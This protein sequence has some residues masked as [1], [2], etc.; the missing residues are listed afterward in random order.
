MRRFNWRDEWPSSVKGPHFHGPA[1]RCELPPDLGTQVALK[2]CVD[3]MAW[4]AYRPATADTVLVMGCAMRRRL[5]WTTCLLLAVCGCSRKEPPQF[6]YIPKL[7]ELSNEL[8]ADVKRELVKYTGTFAQPRLIAA[9]DAPPADL[10]RGQAVYQ[11]RCVQCHGVSGDG[12]GPAAKF[13]YPRPRDYRRGLFKFTSTPYGYRPLP[14][15]LMRT[16]REGIRGTSMPGF[17]LLPEQDLRAVVTYVLMLS[18]RGEL[19]NLLVETA[20]AEDEIDADAVEDDLVATVLRRWDEAEDAE[21]RPITP[22]PRFTAAHVER[23]KQAFLSKGCSK[24]HGDDGR[25]QTLE[26]RGNDAWGQPTRAADLTSGMFR[27]GQ[28]PLDI[29]RRIYAGV[30]GTPMPSFANALQ[31]EPDA[32]WDLVAYVLSVSSHRR[33]GEIPPPGPIKPYLSDAAAGGGE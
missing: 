13:M 31:S 30:N 20:E 12:Q 1:E 18:R 24:C 27:G 26:N 5:V 2:T 22:Q 25:G 33:G 17:A 29:Y 7:S 16:V 3:E 8:Q 32:I 15:D 28:R 4:L 6:A 14:S 19:E 9:P 23:G 21:V 11:E 10:A